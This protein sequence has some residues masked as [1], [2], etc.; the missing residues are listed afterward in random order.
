M[1]VHHDGV[2]DV[3]IMELQCELSKDGR[4]THVELCIGQTVAFSAAAPA[5]LEERLT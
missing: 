1:I 5:T 4:K 3:S 2:R